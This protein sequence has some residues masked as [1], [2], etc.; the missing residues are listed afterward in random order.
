[1]TAPETR[2]ITIRIAA[3]REAT[4]AGAWRAAL[5]KLQPA[6]RL[7]PGDGVYTLEYRFP[8]VAVTDI[9]EA[10]AAAGLGP[11]MRLSSRWRCRIRGIEEDNERERLGLRLGW[12]A[13]VEAV[14]A[15]YFE[16]RRGA[17]SDTRRQHWQDYG[18]QSPI[19]SNH[20]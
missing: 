14:H 6:P 18:R 2:A 4:S 20:E 16:R 9:L 19:L 12:H 5:G 8:D 7:I 17:S 13:Y 11:A 15:H 1:M 3:Q 10:L